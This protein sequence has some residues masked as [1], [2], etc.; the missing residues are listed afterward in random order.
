MEVHRLHQGVG[1]GVLLEIE[2]RHLGERVNPGV[3]AT[4][5]LDQHALAA[6]APDRLLQGRLHRGAVGLALPA[7][8]VGAVILDGDLVARH[9]STVPAGSAKPRK[10]ASIGIGALPARCTVSSRSAP[11]PQAIVPASRSEEHTSELQSLM[12]IS[13]AVF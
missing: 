8:E 12:R 11:A 9:G 4:R 5:A 7:D 2:V 6:E 3:G 1:G 10:K 13:Y